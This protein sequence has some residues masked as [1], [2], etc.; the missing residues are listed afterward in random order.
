MR[1]RAFFYC[2]PAVLI[3]I[4]LWA[5]GQVKSSRNLRQGD[6]VAL[7]SE[8]QP[9]VLNPYLP[10]TEAERQLV[11]LIHEPLV[12]LGPDGK[13]APAL[14]QS[15]RWMKRAT[16]WFADNASATAARQ[17]LHQA[18]D[19]W[20]GWHLNSARAEGRALEL[21]FTDPL[22]GALRET[23][24]AASARVQAVTILRIEVPG[25]AAKA[26]LALV[27]SPVLSS[28]VQRWWFNGK[29]ALELAVVAAT[30]DYASQLQRHLERSLP[31]GATVRLQVAAALPVLEEPMLDFTLREDARWHTGSPVTGNDVRATWEA[32]VNRSW[33]LPQ[34]EGLRMV[35]AVESPAPHHVYMVLWQHYGPAL[36]AWIDLPIL[37]A[38]WLKNHPLDDAGRVFQ[39]STPPGAGRCRIEQ[40][41]HNSLVIRPVQ[42]ASG[43][44]HRL[45]LVTSLSGFSSQLGY[46]TQALDLFWPKAE[47]LPATPYDEPLIARTSPHREVAQV[48]FNTRHEPLRD[49][50][51]RQ[52]L[53]LGVDRA[54]LVASALPGAA[55]PHAGLF[56]PG[57]WLSKAA[58]TPGSS[59]PAA[60][61]LLSSAGWLRNASGTASSTTGALVFK[62]LAPAEDE[63]L[64]RMAAVLRLQWLRLGVQIVVQPLTAKALRA[65]LDQRAFD[66]VLQRTVPSV[67]WDLTSTWHSRSP[68][69]LT[70]YESRPA[71]LLLEA[72]S[73]EFDA[74][75]AALRTARLEQ[76]LLEESPVIPLLAFHDTTMLRASLATTAQE[77]A[78]WTLRTLM[79]VQIA[80]AKQGP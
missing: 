60:E 70:G 34:A 1:V 69:N 4:T 46:R 16:A 61:E 80:E 6:L 21:L 73:Q 47:A 18:K 12:R 62:L 65:A 66:A 39:Q 26:H 22:L 77:E 36:C 35:R 14:A 42:P 30:P 19:R 48:V 7:M 44:V 31:A 79:D 51:V 74:D 20:G 64:L 57:L 13:P 68:A 23:L 75:E 25:Q 37:P 33:P 63:P 11:E 5:V 8:R 67:T 54:T 59:L 29:D 58:A 55:V 49:A 38:D 2:L 53:A 41:D 9:P 50:K 43:S 40:R 10:A 45:T 78:G 72:L 76:L 17:R 24:Q 32:I 52:A 56:G 27:A 15:W 28:P 3:G 71:D